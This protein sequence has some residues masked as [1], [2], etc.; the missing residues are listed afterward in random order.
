[1]GDGLGVLG[2]DN[3]QLKAIEDICPYNTI[4]TITFLIPGEAVA[5][6]T[7]A[8]NGALMIQ[9]KK[10]VEK[11]HDT[12]DNGIREVHIPGYQKPAEFY[13][14]R[15]TPD[16]HIDGSDLR[17]TIYWNPKIE[18]GDNGKSEIEFYTTDAPSTTYD[19]VIEG[20]TDTGI[21]FSS[22]STISIE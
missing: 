20:I 21:P 19:I 7:K 2:S 8:A 5:L 14:P 3:N 22:H 17:A 12:W 11:P 16:C 13:S 4:K 10:D 15:Y 1:M 6:G 18:I 9:T